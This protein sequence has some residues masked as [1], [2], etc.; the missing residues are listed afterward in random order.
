M[1]VFKVWIYL[2]LFVASTTISTWIFS[3]RFYS[4]GVVFQRA[5]VYNDNQLESRQ[6]PQGIRGSHASHTIIEDKILSSYQLMRRRTISQ[7]CLTMRMRPDYHLYNHLGAK[8]ISS[9]NHIIVLDDLKLM[10]CCIPHTGCNY[11]KHLFQSY[12]L[13]ERGDVERQATG[14]V[15]DIRLLSQYGIGEVKQ[16]LLNYSSFIFTR[17]PFHRLLSAF[18]TSFR[19][20]RGGDDKEEVRRI[21][22]SK[23]ERKSESGDRAAITN[24]TLDAISFPEFIDFI[25]QSHN[26]FHKSDEANWLGMYQLCHLCGIDYD[27]VGKYETFADDSKEAFEKFGLPGVV[28][29]SEIEREEEDIS[30]V[31]LRHYFSQLNPY[32]I[33]NFTKRFVADKILFGYMTPDV[34][35]QYLTDRH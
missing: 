35:M 1:S 25:S 19:L 4:R 32:Q 26:K 34:V 17:N 15:S 33:G 10:F 21:Y 9:L 23:I 22:K 14:R 31:T 12:R 29:E 16:R 11:W 7:G 30:D 24:K 8:V 3:E 2:G 5:S 6:L 28:N 18:I 27:F 13:D 20:D